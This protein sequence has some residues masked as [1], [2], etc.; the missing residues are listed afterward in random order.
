MYAD[1]TITAIYLI[2]LISML[3]A[4]ICRFWILP[5]TA[6]S[7]PS[8]LYA[9]RFF[10]YAC[11]SI[12]TITSIIMFIT[13]SITMNNGVFDNFYIL[14]STVL[15]QTH[16]GYIMLLRFVFLSLLW[17][18]ALIVK[19]DSRR[20]SLPACIIFLLSLLIVFTSS[21]ISHAGDNGDFTLSVVIDCL[22]IIST[23]GWGGSIIVV[24]ICVLPL[25]SALTTSPFFFVDLIHRL[26][27]IST[28]S[29]GI[30]LLTGIYNAW[31]YLGSISEL[32]TSYAGKILSIKLCFVGV[33]IFI[34]AIN[35]FILSPR[36]KRAAISNQT[37]I[38]IAL[39]KTTLIADVFLI[40]IILFLATILINTMPPAMMQ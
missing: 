22:H 39:I 8:I 13:R 6:F 32:W 9:S 3:G 33:M 1:I 25:Y 21:S 28:I 38:T 23:A 27:I 40:A 37:T 16:Y 31:W 26:S 10:F 2:A 12:I 4:L 30:I 34:G 17:I 5:T 36:I 15:R 18:F 19:N 35:K 11:L 20:F 7:M 14:I 24:V 29:L